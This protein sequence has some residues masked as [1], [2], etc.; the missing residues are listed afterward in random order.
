MGKSLTKNATRG[1]L[2]AGAAKVDI[3]PQDLTGLTNLWGR[4]FEGVHDPIFLRAL[5]VDN[6]INKAAIVAADLVEFG[7]T[8]S[9]RKRIAKEIGIPVD[10][11]IITASHDHNAPRVGTV[12]A[13]ATAHA[14]GPATAA[15]TEMVY[16]QIIEVVRQAKAALQ[17]ARLGIGTGKADVNTNRDEYTTEGWKVGVNPEGPSEKTVWVV[18][19]ETTSGE[20]IAILMNYAVHS[21]VLGAENRLVTGDLAGAA[22][23]F[24]EQ[25]YQD[26]V[27]AL[28]TLGPAGDQNPRYVSWD[29]ASIGDRERE[30][31]YSLMDALGQILGEEV[32][33]VAG[34]IEQMT[35]EARIE[36]NERVVSCPA[37]IP[38]RDTQCDDLKFQPVDS[39]NIHLGL[40]LINHFALTSVSGE[41]VTRI[42]RHLKKVSPFVNTILITLAN[43]RVGYIVDDASYDIPTFESTN[44][45]LKRGHA[46]AA[47]VNGLLEMMDLYQ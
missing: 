19:F 29:T 14:G 30:P 46:E 6:S 32:L 34:R 15:Y 41:V 2:R 22:E 21:V 40:V 18:K 16:D 38:T 33:Q 8:S 17:P 25:Y 45:P 47:I 7:D 43:D 44:T 24:V 13:G 42:Y 20:P 4:P 3:T 10:H 9:V 36:A 11:I 26:K 39:L 31:G 23:R 5:V 35:A 27:V 1:P 28:W 37:R 12:T